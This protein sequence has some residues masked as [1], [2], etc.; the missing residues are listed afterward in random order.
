MN[1]LIIDTVFEEMTKVPNENK[2][3]SESFL[4]KQIQEQADKIKQEILDEQLKLKKFLTNY[5]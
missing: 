5:F 3:L 2:I 1:D 4:L